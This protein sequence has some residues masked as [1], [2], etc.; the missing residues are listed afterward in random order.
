MEEGIFE[1]TKHEFFRNPYPDDRQTSIELVSQGQSVTAH[2]TRTHELVVRVVNQTHSLGNMWV[3]ALLGR[4]DVQQAAYSKRHPQD[5]S[6]EL[7][8]SCTDNPWTA[9]ADALVTCDEQL[10]T[11]EEK[12]VGGGKNDTPRENA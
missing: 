9:L 7:S 3:D 11:F 1:A 10:K 8:L 4:A 2:G 6:I 12:F 5:H